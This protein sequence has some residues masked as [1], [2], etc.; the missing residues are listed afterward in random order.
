VGADADPVG[1]GVGAI[2]GIIL[3]ALA[4]VVIAVL[5]GL[6]LAKKHAGRN[7][8]LQSQ[9]INTTAKQHNLNEDASL[10]NL[11]YGIRRGKDELLHAPPLTHTSDIEAQGETRSRLSALFPAPDS[12]Q[13]TGWRQHTDTAVPTADGY[14][15]SLAAALL[16]HFLPKSSRWQSSRRSSDATMFTRVSE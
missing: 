11:I 9:T 5:V 4:I 2:V 6:A 16:Q 10:G 15:I 12:V 14:D 3:G 1:F 13:E 7:T 8:G